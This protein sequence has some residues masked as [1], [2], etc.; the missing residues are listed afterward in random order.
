MMPSKTISETDNNLLPETSSKSYVSRAS[1]Q[2]IDQS[3]ILSDETLRGGTDSLR[4][5]TKGKGVL[6][7]MPDG[8]GFLRASGFYPGPNDIYISQSQIRRFDIRPGDEVEGLVRPPKDMERYHGMLKVTKINGVEPEKLNQRVRFEQMTAV[9]PDKQIK[10]ETGAKPL[11]TRLIDLAAPIGFGQRGMIVSPP[12][13]GKTTILKEIANGITSNHKDVHLM[14]VL[15]GERPEEVTDI[16]RNV[17]GEVVLLTLTNQQRI[18]LKSRR[19]HLSGR[20]DWLRA[21]RT[22][23]F[24]LTVLPG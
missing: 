18:K 1:S 10:L 12:K 22:W 15:I 20:K 13:A 8:Y 7:L 4:E 2:S 14:A 23:L 11:S 21:G 3:D 17:K 5:A 19:C 24:Y 6:E 16:T 9:Y